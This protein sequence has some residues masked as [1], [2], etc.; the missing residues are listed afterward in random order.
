MFYDVFASSLLKVNGQT[1]SHKTA[2]YGSYFVGNDSRVGWIHLSFHVLPVY[3]QRCIF[4][5]FG[6]RTIS[7]Y[8]GGMKSHGGPLR[9]RGIFDCLARLLQISHS[10]GV[11]K[12]KASIPWYGLG[13]DR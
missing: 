11:D 4:V 1:V 13:I 6:V 5:A 9:S 3:K 2:Y 12:L 7:V 8:T 10:R